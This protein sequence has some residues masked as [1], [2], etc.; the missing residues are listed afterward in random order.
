MLR[1]EHCH[2]LFCVHGIERPHSGAGGEG[3]P[4]QGASTSA[5]CRRSG[6]SLSSESA[7]NS[8]CVIALRACAV[9]HQPAIKQPKA[10]NCRFAFNSC[11]YLTEA[12]SSPNTATIFFQVDTVN[13]RGCRHFLDNQNFECCFK[14]RPKSLHMV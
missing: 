4:V 7:E 2:T 12:H 13:I 14:S 1:R 5:G 3:S 8:C 10:H 11:M 9:L 6:S